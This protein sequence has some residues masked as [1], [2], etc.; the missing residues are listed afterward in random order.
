MLRSS[1][2]AFVDQINP[3]H[4]D[5]NLGLFM[6][7]NFVNC[8]FWASRLG[9]SLLSLSLIACGDSINGAGRL[10]EGAMV[11]P[12]EATILNVPSGVTTDIAGNLYVADSYN[13]TIRKITRAGIVSTVAGK[14]GVAGNADGEGSAAR[15]TYPY[16]VTSDPAGNL[17]VADTYNHTIRKIGASGVVSTLAG[18]AGS[19]G[20]SDGAGT[21]ARFTYPNAIQV[22]AAGNLYVADTSN[23]TIRKITPAGVVS[24]LAG[25]AGKAGHNDGPGA[26]AQFNNP[27]GITGDA[28]GNLYV[29]DTRNHTIRKITPTG[30]VSTLAGMAGKAGSADGNGATARFHIPRGITADAAGNLYVTDTFNNTVRKISADSVV[31][32]LAGAAGNAGQADGTGRGALFNRPYGI[33]SDSAGNLYVIDTENHNIRKIT[34]E[35]VVNTI[36]GIKVAGPSAEKPAS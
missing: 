9:V 2:A 1:S 22:D 21:A 6:H 35:G 33:R 18:L 36:A 25:I 10:S 13:H 28:A 29:A 16:G 8:K 26:S 27:H 19:A 12:P 24:T 4:G 5:F 15:L 31:S 32:T 17:Y 20:S 7:I 3:F 14:A 34:P 23:H 11:S 30:A